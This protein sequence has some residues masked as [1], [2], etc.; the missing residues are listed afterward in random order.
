MLLIREKPF[1]DESLAGYVLRTAALNMMDK[2]TW[3]FLLYKNH[4][5]HTVR[6]DDL[7]WLNASNLTYLSEIIGIPEHDLYCHTFESWSQF[8]GIPMG[9]ERKSAWFLH[10]TTKI[11]PFC[12]EENSYHRIWWS[13][14]HAT[15][16]PL[17][18]IYLVDSCEHCG[19]RF[20]P[21]ETVSKKCQCGTYIPFSHTLKVEDEKVLAHQE[22]F[23]SYLNNPSGP[24]HPWICSSTDYFKAVE[25]LAKWIPLLTS[26]VNS[27]E[28]EDATLHEK[29]TTRFRL[30]RNRPW[31]Y[32]ALLYSKANNILMNWPVYY[33]CFLKDVETYGNKELGSFVRSALPNLLGTNLEPFYREFNKF[34][35]AEKTNLPTETRI[36][37]EREA[38]KTL[39]INKKY[40]EKSQ[41]L[42]SI[43]IIYGQREYRYVRY[44]D[45]VAWQSIYSDFLTQEELCELWGLGKKIIQE[46]I[47]S[48]FFE[49]VSYKDVGAVTYVMIPKESIQTKTMKMIYNSSQIERKNGITIKKLSQS[50]SRLVVIPILDACINAALPFSFGTN[51]SEITVDKEESLIY[52]KDKIL[53]GSRQTQQ[54]TLE[55]VSFLL[56]VKIKDVIHWIN[57]GRFGSKVIHKNSIPYASY[58]QFNSNFLTTTQLSEITGLS[59]KQI[60][61]KHTKG[62]ITSVAGPCH[63]DGDRL[64]FPTSILDVF[65]KLS[66]P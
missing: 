43:N 28:C 24:K 23:Q 47:S 53:E 50:Y 41:D 56:G 27:V 12:I 34:L 60:I 49:Y 10:H 31:R 26:T 52:V 45:T 35:V 18:K 36:I 55:E 30:K 48:N 46:L 6:E 19:R 32:S 7:N 16:C 62:T 58:A 9:S 5:G 1:S 63:N 20:R 54:L 29:I 11:C 59:T 57:T 3:I 22:I 42:A 33:H 61:S 66:N 17:H 64:L 39:N 37:T 13:L 38:I 15:I 51:I 21:R 25:F 8:K 2:L 40:L 4:I 14:T 65:K 44:K